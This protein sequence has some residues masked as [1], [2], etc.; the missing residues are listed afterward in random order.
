M[1]LELEKNWEA[2]AV[3]DCVRSLRSRLVGGRGGSGRTVLD[4][5]GRR[6]AGAVA[7][8]EVA[9]R[10]DGEVRRSGEVEEFSGIG[11]TNLGYCLC[12]ISN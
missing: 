6:S 7:E 12:V 11:S 5:D 8:W 10:A 3:V 2:S 9:G 4:D 1:E